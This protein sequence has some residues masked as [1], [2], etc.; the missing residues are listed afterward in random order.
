VQEVKEVDDRIV[1]QRDELHPV[2]MAVSDTFMI[3]FMEPGT[4]DITSSIMLSFEEEG[5]MVLRTYKEVVAKK[6]AELEK[7]LE[8]DWVDK[9]RTDLQKASEL[10]CMPESENEKKY[11]EELG[12]F[13]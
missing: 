8:P 3:N 10:E 2:N 7:K 12:N 9:V 11:D 13:K 6:R 1:E 5:I 4:E